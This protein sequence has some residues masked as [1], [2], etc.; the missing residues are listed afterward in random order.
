MVDK[1]LQSVHFRGMWISEANDCIPLSFCMEQE[2]SMV[3]IKLTSALR[4]RVTISFVFNFKTLT[5]RNIILF[6]LFISNQTENIAFF[7]HLCCFWLCKGLCRSY[8][9]CTQSCFKWGSWY[10]QQ[11]WGKNCLSSYA[12]HQCSFHESAWFCCCSCCNAEWNMQSNVWSWS[13]ELPSFY[14]TINLADVYNPIVKFLSGSEFDLDEILP[15]D[16]PN[17]WEQASLVAQNPF[18]AAK[19]LTAT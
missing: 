7:I 2:V 6:S 18:V 13:S 4:V 16:Y 3:T 1:Y 11:Q 17:Y 8:P 10:C 9:G 14:I 12:W 15:E 5:F 19:F